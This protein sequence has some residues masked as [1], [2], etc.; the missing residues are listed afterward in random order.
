MRR[1]TLGALVA[2][3]AVLATSA[4]AAQ[5]RF[6]G[7]AGVVTDSSQAPV[8]GATVTATNKQTGA[9]RTV[10]SGADGAYRIPDLEPGRYTVTVELSGFQKV[11]ADDVLVLL[12]R[13]AD[14]PAM[15]KVGGV[16]EVVHGQRRRREADRP[17]QHDDRA[18]RHGGRVR[19][20]AEG[21]QLPGHR[22]DVARREPGRHRRRLPGERRQR[23]REQLHRRRRRTPTAC[24]TAARARTPCSSTCRKCR[25]R[26]A[27]SRPSTAARSA[28][29]SARSPSRAATGSPAKATTT[30]RATRSRRSPVQRLQ[31]S[32]LDDTTVLNV[33]DDKQN[34][35][36]QRGRRVDRRPDRARIS[37]SSSA[38][39]RRASSGA[40]TTTSSRTAPSRARSRRTQTATQAFGK[41]T[42]ASRRVQANGSVLCDAAAL[43]RHADGLRRHRPAVHQQ[44]ARRQR[45]AD[46]RAASSRIR[47]TSAATSTSI[48]SGAVVAQR[49]RR[50]FHD[51]YKDTGVSTT[52]AVIWN[53]P[54]IGVAGVPANLQLPKGAQNTPRVLITN[55]DQ[56]KTGFFQVDY[57][58]AF[59]AAG[60]HLLKG[61]VGVR[62]TTNDVDSTYPGRLRAPQLGHVVRQQQ[63]RRPAP[64]PTATTR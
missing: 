7:L 46:R 22:A 41:V 58:H 56:T 30:T 52:T 43:D 5:E 55:K 16:S 6:G 13:T 42:Y 44:L 28:A 10:V 4:I 62:H 60:S 32:P 27:A 15:L 12:G 48:L 14:F 35:Q 9:A 24:C 54:S 38:R 49:A 25:S 2:L 20:H 47:P 18:Q 51:N 26:P 23:R 50:L 34:E 39:S 53:T 36:P 64:A 33:Q 1:A 21:A 19:P 59:N 63:R 11:Q 3:I 61:G 57:N 29:S 40:P 17:A 37:C 31:L 8:P 45:R